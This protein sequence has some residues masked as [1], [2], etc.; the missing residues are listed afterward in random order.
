MTNCVELCSLFC[1]LPVHKRFAYVRY[2]VYRGSENS[3][4]QK[5][6]IDSLLNIQK[7]FSLHKN[8]RWIRDECESN[9]PKTL[10][11]FELTHE[12]LA[13]KRLIPVSTV[14]YWC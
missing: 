8:Y 11:V 14:L 12:M 3:N 6:Q 13:E 4:L 9:L 7:K 1:Y 5:T 10:P 2:I